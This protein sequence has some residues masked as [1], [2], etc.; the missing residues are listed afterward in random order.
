[1]ELIKR[2]VELLVS[3]YDTN[4]P[5]KLAKLL[6]IKVEFEY[7]GKILGY[8]N[9]NFRCQLIHLNENTEEH[10]QFF[11]CSHELGHAI[12][13]PDENT[14]FLKKHTLFS[15][16]KIETEANNFALELIFSKNDCIT[17]EDAINKYGVP[18]QLALL[19]SLGR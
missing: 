18:K 17:I 3:K 19:K 1:M 4:C 10:K 9:K 12:L 16:S 5:F 2:K 15:T 6:G 13:H 7:L 11:V 14:P 8:Y